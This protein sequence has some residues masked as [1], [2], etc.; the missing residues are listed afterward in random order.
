MLN[1]ERKHYL[2]ASQ[3]HIAM[4]GFETEL[5]GRSMP[6]PDID[7]GAL[8]TTL[9]WIRGHSA[10]PKVGELK[11]IG[12][13]LSGAQINEIYSYHRSQIKVFSDGMETAALQIA[14]SKFILERDEGYKSPDMERGN[15]Q[16]GEAINALSELTGIEFDSTGIGQQFLTKGDLGVTPDGIEYSGFDIVSCAEAKNP[17]DTTHMRYLFN[18][19]DQDDL[20]RVCPEYYWQAQSG[21][22]VTGAKIYHWVS[23]HNGF[24][25]ECRLVYI[26][27]TPNQEHI[28]MLVLRAARIMGRV[29]MIIDDI[30]ER[31]MQ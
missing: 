27:V 30:K 1:P 20:L 21:L 25:P 23:Y 7:D 17:K 12:I 9:S 18:L 4:A 11:A 31:K 22:Y 24:I 5:A 29:P 2:T 8:A 6:K 16:E 3:A 14:M 26:P 10:K 13:N 15:I 19:K 28:D